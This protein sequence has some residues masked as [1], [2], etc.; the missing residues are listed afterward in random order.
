MWEEIANDYHCYSEMRKVW[1]FVL[2]LLGSWSWSSA[3]L[4]MGWW[5]FHVAVSLSGAANYCAHFLAWV[6]RVLD[7]CCAVVAKL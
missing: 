4:S 2:G 3:S 7:L 1:G 6:E 5:H